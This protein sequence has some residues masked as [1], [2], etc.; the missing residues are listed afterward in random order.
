MSMQ[1]S[2]HPSEGHSQLQDNPSGIY[3]AFYAYTSRTHLGL[4][5]QKLITKPRSLVSFLF[6]RRG[7][8]FI[9]FDHV[10]TSFL[11]GSFEPVLILRCSLLLP[12]FDVTR[13]GSAPSFAGSLLSRAALTPLGLRSA[14]QPW[15][16]AAWRRWVSTRLGGSGL[17]KFSGLRSKLGV[18]S[19]RS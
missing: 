14:K 5:L 2:Q 11:D 18:T 7:T 19:L 9:D 1:T 16:G 15:E 3:Q 13:L 8:V 17:F 10:P 6:W 4:K 12:R